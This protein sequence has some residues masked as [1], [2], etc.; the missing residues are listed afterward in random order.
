M[1]EEEYLSQRLD[2][3]IM[4]YDEKSTKNQ[5]IYKGLRIAEIVL[6]A[7]ITVMISLME[8]PLYL[9]LLI[10]ISSAVISIIAA[11]HGICK[12]QENWIKYRNTC[13]A[14]KQEKFLYFT[15]AGIYSKTDDPF[16]LL[17]EQC[18]RI[19]STEH[20]DWSQRQTNPLHNVRNTNHSSSIGS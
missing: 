5:Y 14:L 15:K 18:E 1:K 11:V 9:K 8:G 6:S 16:K 10:A 3:Q 19:M 17:V 4:W 7:S 20:I 2:D 13:E 12:F